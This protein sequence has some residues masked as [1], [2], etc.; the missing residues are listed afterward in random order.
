LTQQLNVLM[1]QAGRKL[2]VTSALSRRAMLAR[3]YAH[4]CDLI[5]ALAIC[6]PTISRHRWTLEN[7]RPIK[8]QGLAGGTFSGDRGLL[9][10]LSPLVGE[11]PEPARTGARAWRRSSACSA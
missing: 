10:R 8:Y 2:V 5:Q 3:A 7:T 11:K 1:N 9:V 4:V 6:G